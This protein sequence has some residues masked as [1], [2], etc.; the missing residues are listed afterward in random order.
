MCIYCGTDKYRRIYE[1]HVGPIPRDAN[2]RKYEVHHIDGNHSNNEPTNLIALSIQE[3]YDV[4]YSQGDWWA[5]L[6]I[7]EKMKLSPEEISALATKSNLKRI[8]AGTHPFLDGER[9][10][11]IQNER[12]KNGTHPFLN[13]ETQRRTQRRRIEEGIH[14][15]LDSEAA[16]ARNNKRVASGT[17]PFQR[18]PD[19]T[20]RTSDRV[21]DG[22]NPFLKRE[23]GSSVASDRVKKGT[24]PWQ[25]GE[26]HKAK[27]REM[28]ENGTHP[29]QQLWTCEHCGSTGKGASNFKRWH[30][31]KCKSK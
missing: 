8:A 31:D 11:Q 25:G 24:H 6:R 21:K 7:A 4:H 12:V 2:G 30:G 10:R 1:S 28:L 17:H 23:D 5:C 15:F 19:G 13:S 18:R 26:Y 14:H 20:S 27:N 3:H 22:T 29:S 16:S 9:N